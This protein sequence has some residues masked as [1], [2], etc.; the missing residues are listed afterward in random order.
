MHSWIYARYKVTPRLAITSPIHD[1]GKSTLMLILE[2]L[3]FHG[4]KIDD[5]SAASVYR[6]LDK[7]VYSFSLDELDEVNWKH[8]YALKRVI[9]SGYQRGGKVSRVIDGEEKIFSTF[10]PMALAAIRNP[11]PWPVLSRSI[12]IKMQRSRREV[13][14]FDTS[15]F[16]TI[17]NQIWLWAK[18]DLKLDPKP[19]MPKGLR[20][21]RPRDK[22]RPLFAIADSFGPEWGQRAR[23][24]ALAFVRNQSE[25]EISVQLL[26]DLRELFTA[27]D[28]DRALSKQLVKQ[29]RALADSPWNDLALTEAKLAKMLEPFDIKPGHIRLKGER[30]GRGYLRAWF[31]DAWHRYCD[32]DDEEEAPK[33]SA[34]ILRFRGD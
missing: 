30:Q 23:E 19:E 8:A 34:K 22:W 1:C 12:H 9:N 17:R 7:R 15:I 18:P 13:A 28:I 29:L 2:Q 4:I 26:E 20:V 5:A 10:A 14:D 33:K 31:E 24:A 27:D 16:D 25:T 11:L 32:D 6:L 21:G 3:T